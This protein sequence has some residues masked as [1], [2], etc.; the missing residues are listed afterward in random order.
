MADWDPS[1]ADWTT[2]RFGSPKRSGSA[3]IWGKP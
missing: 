1:M 3:A 2:M